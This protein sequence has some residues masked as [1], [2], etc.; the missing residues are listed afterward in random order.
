MTTIGTAVLQIIPSLD[1]VSK[2]VEKQLGS[3][4]GKKFGKAFGK[5]LADGVR[6]SEADVKKAFESHAKLADKAADATGKL[7]VAQAGYQDLV[8]KGVRSG[9]RFERAKEAVEK[10]TRDE[11]RATRAATDALKDYEKAQKRAADGVDSIGSGLGERL[12]NLAGDAASGGTSAATSFVEGFGGPV[13]AIGTKAGPI[14]VALTAAAALATGAGVLIAKNVMAGMD[15]ELAADR[16]QAQLGLSDAE[17][18]Q[19]G[20]SAGRVYA[21]AFG[22]SRGDVNQAMADVVSTARDLSG[23]ALEDITAKALTFRDLYGTDVAE[24]IALAQNM[25]VNGLAPDASAA[26]DLMT[27]ASQRFPA[28]MRDELPDLLQEYSTYFQSLGFSGEEALGLL[29]KMAPQGKIALDKVGDSLK[30]LTIRATDLE[31]TGAQDILAAMGLNGQDVS[32]NLLAGGEQ[33]NEQ[34][35]QI[36][37]KLLGIQDPASQAAAAIAL[38]GTPLEDLDK[39]KIPAFLA[40]MDDA[41]AAMDGFAGSS[42]EMVDT[43]GDNAATSIE[44]AKRAVDTG[45]T[46]MQTSLAQAFGPMAKDIS[47]WVLENE[48]TITGFFMTAAN[49]GAEFGSAMLGVAS[50]LVR[51]FGLIVQATGQTVDFILSSF[52]GLVGG[53][54]TI[55]DAVG[56]DG[57][58]G[59]LRGA[60]EQMGSWS[61]KLIDAGD[62]MVAFSD[63]IFGAAVQLHD[64]DANL[65]S[66][67]TSA[68]NA[69]EQ[70]ENVRNQIAALPSGAQI[71]IDAVVV[72]KDQAGRAIDP[73]QLLGFNPSEF[74][75]AGDAQRARRGL[76]YN[77]APAP[78]GPVT[79]TVTS[80]TPTT[81]FVLPSS[82]S[83]SGASSGGGG[84]SSA[85]A[86]FDPS[87][88]S[89][90]AIPASRFSDSG[91]TP[92]AARLNDIIPALF[93]SVTNIGGYRQDPHPDHPSGQALDIMIPGG[94]TR[95]GA[96]PAGKALGDQMWAFLQQNADALGVDIGGSLWQTDTGGDHFD[97][98]HARVNAGAA[99]DG[100]FLSPA[101]S[102]APVAAGPGGFEVDRQAVFDAESKVIQDQQELEEKRLKLLELKADGNA[103][104][105]EI[106]AAENDI[107]QQERDLESSKMKLA[108]A[109]QGKYRE[110]KSS[111]ASGGRSSSGG[112]LGGFG[113]PSSLGSFGETFGS[114]I[115]SFFDGQVSSA[116]DVLGVPQSPGW[117]QGI[118]TLIGGISINGPGGQKIGGG[119]AGSALAGV[120]SMFGNAGPAAARA[121]LGG[122]VQP[123]AGPAGGGGG[124]P[125][126]PTFNTTIQARDAEGAMDAWRRWQNERT[127]AKLS[128]Y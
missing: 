58:A 86:Y 23:A 123:P 60:Q 125:G 38:F 102:A 90:D 2:S 100:G 75:T 5:D 20:E 118:S 35:D 74:A 48:D 67:Q 15:R 68:Q 47:D 33:A 27:T 82:A 46:S 36:I 54:A 85:P 93:P 37:D 117:L 12:K 25:I 98:I 71:N 34:F 29:V 115:G 66:T 99:A 57:L 7:K 18:A 111:V 50:G 109:K 103:K 83:G 17:V 120:G 72:Y 73:A 3:L 65:G 63:D 64:F 53:A 21:A 105:S 16:I 4:D 126:G 110:A 87:L 108:E 76:P 14:G 101:M 55:A 112:S 22:D 97:H 39:A 6:A 28:A 80:V 9:Q 52:E 32:N 41:A 43:V 104:Q 84:S 124:R 42:Q 40:S 19:F 92:N 31:D 116:L 122:G 49:A 121:G 44:G 89:L 128:H 77:A 127:A 56:L 79:P 13:A 95:G 45:V 11:V 96:N 51:T 8:D 24:S 10:A 61:Q 30:E 91:L 1:G 62:D 106:L 119:S 114:A 69:A 107:E 81:P 59:D 113:V 26:F 88:W 78:S 70:I 94:T